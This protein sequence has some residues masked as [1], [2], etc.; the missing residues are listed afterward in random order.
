MYDSGLGWLVVVC[1]EKLDV[2]A[3]IRC[4]VATV[5]LDLA[6]R[7]VAAGDDS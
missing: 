2:T 1:L 5:V 4:E 3:L 6:N 7:K